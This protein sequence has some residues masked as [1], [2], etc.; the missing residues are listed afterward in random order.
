MLNII[1]NLYNTV[2]HILS[3]L[4]EIQTLF[5]FSL[6]VVS[7]FLLLKNSVTRSLFYKFIKR[8][9]IALLIS[10]IINLLMSN[11]TFCYS[12]STNTKENLKLVGVAGISFIGG[13]TFWLYINYNKVFLDYRQT[14][15]EL[16]LEYKYNT[17]SDY[18]Q[19]FVKK[20]G[21]PQKFVNDLS[22][23]SP[24]MMWNRDLFR[25]FQN[26]YGNT[27]SFSLKEWICFGVGVNHFS[28]HIEYFETLKKVLW[29]RHKNPEIFRAAY[30]YYKNPGV[31]RVPNLL[32]IEQEA[33]AYALADMLLLL[34]SQ[35]KYLGGPSN[36]FINRKFFG[37]SSIS[38][39]VERDSFFANF[40]GISYDDYIK[41]NGSNR[42]SFQGFLEHL[43][44]ENIKVESF[45]WIYPFFWV[46]DTTLGLPNPIPKELFYSTIKGTTEQ[47][48]RSSVPSYFL[49]DS[50]DLFDPFMYSSYGSIL[51]SDT[52][53]K[54]APEEDPYSISKQVKFFRNKVVSLLKR[55]ET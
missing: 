33:K 28:K 19:N 34:E 43:N 13:I 46:L 55:E 30:F 53:N 6:L 5:L 40:S 32:F 25:I 48:F 1:K 11:N 37:P 45:G 41:I 18:A 36:F 42:F 16:I 12:M 51:F 27:V 47:F 38:L 14:I 29:V 2:I 9:I 21:V 10:S 54:F 20:G 35:L 15:D 52:V 23:M 31:P 44:P 8:L 17:I 3:V 24:H 49:I 22:V 26:V 39:S 50:K 7:L 4:N